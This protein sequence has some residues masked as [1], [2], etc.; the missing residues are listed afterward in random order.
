MAGISRI[1]AA[2]LVVAVCAALPGA[3]AWAMSAAQPVHPAGCHGHGPAIPS[4]V[5]YQC[6]VNGHHWAVTSAG[7]VLHPQGGMSVGLDHGE[8]F[9]VESVGVQFVV[10]VVPSIRPPGAVPMRI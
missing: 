1:V 3:Q 7:F 9:S 10:L 5:S 8:E 4:P 6:C 2:L